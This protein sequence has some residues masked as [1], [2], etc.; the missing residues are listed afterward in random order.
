METRLR[1]DMHR[2]GRVVILLVPPGSGKGTQAARLSTALGIPAIS[3]GEILRRECESGSSLGKAVH[4]TLASGQLVSDDLVN[5]VVA[6]RLSRED[7]RGGC[8]LD[9]Y[10]RTVSQAR[11]VQQLLRIL[12]M[13]RPV[14]FD[15]EIESEDVIARLSR[16]RQCTECG[17][18]ITVAEDNGAAEQVC[19]RDGM[20]LAPRADDDPAIISQRLRLYSQNAGELA[21]YYSKRDF[22]RISAARTPEQVSN[23][24][25]GILG[26]RAFAAGAGNRAR[27]LARPQ[28]HA[29]PA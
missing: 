6:N 1:V 24:V 23:E 7:C 10:P 27:A 22:H 8:I 17:R 13:P 3:T 20:K 29:Q 15:F 25:L 28:Y 9:G 18:I 12:K 4:S 19:D 11:F 26:R 21:G 2:R 16:R 14:V 5:Q